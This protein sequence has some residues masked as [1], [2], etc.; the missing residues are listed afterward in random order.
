M[1]TRHGTDGIKTPPRP[2]SHHPPS[3]ITITIT[4]TIITTVMPSFCRPITTSLHL[5]RYPHHPH[6]P[7]TL[8]LWSLAFR[9]NIGN[10]LTS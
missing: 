10:A 8:H 5:Y 9:P 7:P 3:T 2:T 6:H 1:K 4:I